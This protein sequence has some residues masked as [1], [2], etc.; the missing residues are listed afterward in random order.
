ME[1]QSAD[2]SRPRSVSGF[3]PVLP[4]PK[5]WARAKSWQERARIQ[6]LDGVALARMRQFE[7]LNR[8]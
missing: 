8:G 2:R 4:L 1:S 7:R 3:A 5:R 6:R